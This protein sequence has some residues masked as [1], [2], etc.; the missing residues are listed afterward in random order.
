[1]SN[2]CAPFVRRLSFLLDYTLFHNTY[3]HVVTR[4]VG[5][6]PSQRLSDLSSLQVHC[7]CPR[8][9]PALSH[10]GHYKSCQSCLSSVFSLLLTISS[11]I[12]NLNIPSLAK[13]IGDFRFH[14]ILSKPS[15]A[16]YDLAPPTS[17]PSPAALPLTPLSCVHC[18]LAGFCAFVMPCLLPGYPSL[19]FPPL[20]TWRNLMW[21]I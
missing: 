16:C 8:A 15:E 19:S 18:V 10:P 4:L 21:V 6:V 2:C 7:H 13:V 3:I 20:S 5:I 12:S 14:G 11:R 17:L 1:M 9:H